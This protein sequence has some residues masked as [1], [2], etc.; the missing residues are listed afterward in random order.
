MGLALFASRIITGFAPTFPALLRDK[1]GMIPFLVRW[2]GERR[3]DL[4]AI[5]VKRLAQAQLQFDSQPKREIEDAM[6]ELGQEN[7]D[8]S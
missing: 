3:S 7:P 1:I 4:D 6:E 5:A 8:V 2:C